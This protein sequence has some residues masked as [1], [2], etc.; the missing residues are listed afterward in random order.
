MMR[1]A[2]RQNPKRPI[3]MSNMAWRMHTSWKKPLTDPSCILCHLHRNHPRKSEQNTICIMLRMRPGVH[4]VLLDRV[5]KLP[6]CNATRTHRNTS[7]N[8]YAVFMYFSS[9]GEEVQPG[10][11]PEGA[12][13]GDVV[14]VL[15]AIDKD[16]RWPF[17]VVIPSKKIDDPNSYAVKSLETWLLGLG[18]KQFTFQTDQEPAIMKLANMVRKKMGH[19]KMQV[20][21]SPRYSS[22]SLAEGETVNQQIAGRVRTWVSVL[23]EQYQVDIR[24]THRLFPWIV[25]HVAWAM[26]RLHVNTSR[27]TPFRIIKG[28]DFF[29]E[30]LAF[31]EC[32]LAKWPN[33]K[34]LAKGVPRWVHGVF[35][36]KAEG[37]DEHIVLTPVGAQTFR[38]V[39]RLPESS[40]HSLH[41]LES[42]AGLPW[43]A[44]DG[45]SKVQPAIVVS[46]PGVEFVPVL[47]LYLHTRQR[48]QAQTRNKPCKTKTRSPYVRPRNQ[49]CKQTTSQMRGCRTSHNSSTSPHHATVTRALRHPS[50]TALPACMTLRLGVGLPR[51]NCQ[52]RR[53]MPHQARFQAQGGWRL[54]PGW[55]AFQQYRMSCWQ[56]LWKVT[57]PHVETQLQT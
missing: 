41:S 4:T 57:K 44:K 31:G 40:R 49:N 48:P 55:A 6:T 23:S 37:S 7:C 56:N 24:N 45:S 34:D 5:G 29:G 50:P 16:S 14:T 18:W 13:G 15:T 17:A 51:G 2:R 47:P 8:V 11:L 22:Q 35:V 19:D 36:G 39:R 10:D 28:H 46:K 27:T 32:V 20:R 42:V 12:D 25:R 54:K 9:K 21:Q 3:H 43:D 53:V 30:L 33:M 26:A 1:Q 52:M 38:T